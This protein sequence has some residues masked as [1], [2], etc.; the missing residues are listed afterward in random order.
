MAKEAGTVKIILE[1]S[2]THASITAS[3]KNEIEIK[4]VHITA[5]KPINVTAETTDASGGK[6]AEAQNHNILEK[7]HDEMLI[8][9]RSNMMRTQ[10]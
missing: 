1:D 9:I 2:S 8:A 3:D 4:G 10:L 5:G 7:L 6:K